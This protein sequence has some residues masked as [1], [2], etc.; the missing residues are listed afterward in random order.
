MDFNP[1]GLATGIGSFPQTDPGAAC[2]QILTCMPEIP[3]WP[4]LPNID[5][6]E[7]MEIQYAEGFPCVV[8]DDIKK[9]MHFE[10]GEDPT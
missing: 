10:I 4:Q 2:E 3:L 6:H 7:Q 1:K 8:F 9:R 5:F